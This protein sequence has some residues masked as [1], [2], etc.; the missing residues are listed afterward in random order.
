MGTDSHMALC[1]RVAPQGTCS[2]VLCVTHMQRAESGPIYLGTWPAC[3]SVL[4]GETRFGTD[5]G[6]SL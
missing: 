4:S 2:L 5:D 3:T 6:V 1:L